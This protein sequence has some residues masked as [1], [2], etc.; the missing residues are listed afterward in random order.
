MKS[1]NNE[2]LGILD[3][4]AVVSF[5]IAIKNLQLNNEQV[6][7]LQEHLKKQDDVLEQEQNKMLE[8][9]IKQNEE[10]IRLLKGE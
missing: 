3:V 5:I 2:Q 7:S 1:F 8:K 4:L 10:L 9:I 6:A